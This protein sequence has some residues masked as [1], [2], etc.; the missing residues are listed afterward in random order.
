MSK[1]RDSNDRRFWTTAVLRLHLTFV[2]VL[3]SAGQQQLMLASASQD[4]YLRV[5]RIQPEPAKPSSSGSESQK[6]QDLAASIARQG[7]QRSFSCHAPAS[8]SLVCF[9]VAYQPGNHTISSS[10]LFRAESCTVSD[11]MHVVIQ[12]ILCK[13]PPA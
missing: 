13:C 2:Y 8:S 10:W 7:F 11:G 1:K 9:T 3:V 12:L 6:T 5:W 4:K